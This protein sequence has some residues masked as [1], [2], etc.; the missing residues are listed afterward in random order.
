MPKYSPKHIRG[1]LDQAENAQTADEKGD[2]LENLA[3]YIFEKVRG[4]S[5]YDKNILD[6]NRAHEL[7][8]AFWNLQPQSELWFLG[9]II[10]VECKHTGR[11]VGSR[12]VGW[13]VRKLQDRSVGHGILIALSGITGEA[14]G[15][16]NA[17]SEVLTALIRDRVKVLLL[18]RE[19]VLSLEN[20]DD[21]VQ[22]LTAKVLKLV[23]YKTVH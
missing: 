4:V 22:L 9:P 6:Q 18:R 11:P 23:L 13:F 7:D 17:H 15:T 21:L 20:T 1:L 8:V 19:E 5:F 12:D 3:R 14:D 10:I 2:V 16:S